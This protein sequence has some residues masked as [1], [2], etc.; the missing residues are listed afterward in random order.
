VRVVAAFTLQEW[1]MASL[2]A[3][4]EAAVGGQELFSSVPPSAPLKQWRDFA[5]RAPP[6]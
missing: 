4:G 3:E 1:V 2:Q 5:A 6:S